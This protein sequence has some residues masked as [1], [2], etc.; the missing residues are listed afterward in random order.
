MRED[1]G[2]AAAGSGSGYGRPL[3]EGILT[4]CR[5]CC[6]PET[7]EAITFDAMGICTA[8]RS[9]EQKMRINWAERERWLRDIL[10]QAKRRSGANYDCLVPISGGKDST[11]Q[12]H[13]LCKIYGMKPLAVT[14][15]HTWWTDT[16]LYNLRNA[17]EQFKVDHLMFTPNTALVN[18]LAR[19]SLFAI[20][21]ACWH[22]HA[23]V[24]AFPLQVAVKFTIPLI[25]WG[26][27][28]AEHSGK[29]T[30][31]EPITFDRN[32]FLRMSTKVE[33]QRMVGEGI[34]AQDVAPFQ[35]PTPEDIERVGVV[36]IHLSNYL[37]WDAE[38]QVE[39]VKRVYGWREDYVE[40][41]YKQYKS[42]ECRMAGVHDFAKFIKR[43]FGRG[44]DQ[45]SQDARAG[46]M[47]RE[48][49]FE[50]AKA[51]DTQRPP[52]LDDYLKIT[53][54]TEEEFFRTLKAM[55]QGKAKELP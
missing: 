52:G 47:T 33:P 45:A 10:E 21:D 43:G 53:G 3:Y 25:V 34:T 6:L 9:Q 41:A 48:E 55:R 12:L 54:L 37:F 50:M 16:G 39:F 27:S 29:A 4:Y 2:R 22:C 38:R 23:G 1:Q 44:T 5:R 42:V 18:A 13:V 17:L 35:L 20:G 30:Y 26:E 7:S 36:G 31:R 24:G 28:A 51:V 49:A 11:F 40:G 8:C 46:L 19:K 32:Y 15:S 14:F